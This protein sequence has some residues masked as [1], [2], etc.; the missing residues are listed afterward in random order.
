MLILVSLLHIFVEIDRE[1][2]VGSLRDFSFLHYFQNYEI[3]N[4]GMINC[5][6]ALREILTGI[7]LVHT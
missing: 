1:E 5:F 3:K 7:F 4:T 2:Q 6:H